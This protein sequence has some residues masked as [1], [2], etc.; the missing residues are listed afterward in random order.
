MVTF[1]AK[2]QVCS[3]AKR[4]SGDVS[5][6]PQEDV[7]FG[8]FEQFLGLFVEWA[9]HLRWVLRVKRTLKRRTHNAE[10]HRLPVYRWSA[11][12]SNFVH[13]TLVDQINASKVSLRPLN[14]LGKK[15]GDCTPPGRLQGS[16]TRTRYNLHGSTETPKYYSRGIEQRSVILGHSVQEPRRISVS[17]GQ[18]QR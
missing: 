9:I 7:F 6:D 2:V 4:A 1:G 3:E 14:L 11:K 18:E 17:V 8:R 13:S 12:P 15:L 5:R 10:S 16:T